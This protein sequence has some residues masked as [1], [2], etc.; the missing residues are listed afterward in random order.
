MPDPVTLGALV[1]AALSM[2]G[3]ATLKGAVGEAVKDAYKLLKEKV[4]HWAFNDVEALEKTP[5][6]T[7]R[8]A[9]I[10]EIVNARPKD[11]Q[12][13]LRVLAETLVAGLKKSALVVGLDIGRLT[14]LEVDLGNITVTEGI[15]A[16]IEEARVEGTFKTGDISVGTPPGKQ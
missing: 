2:A 4:S 10:A 1:A 3:E 16:R 14:A 13:S 5:A 12:E 11:D 15:G 7:T 8:Q 6:S 9:V